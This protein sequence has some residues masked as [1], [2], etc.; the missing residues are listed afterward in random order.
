VKLVRT[1]LVASLA[2]AG[3][4]KSDT[5][6]SQPAPAAPAAAAKDPATAKKLIAGGAV[7][8][9]VR[10]PEEFGDGHVASATNI[11]VQEL[12]TRIAE[13]DKLVGA[14][15]AKPVVVYC[16]AGKRA[17]RAKAQLEAAG[18]THVVNGGGYDD[19]R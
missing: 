5:P 10:T 7:V 4:S 12:A 19:L 6:N 2:L 3:C 13:V 15:K 14:D 9:D 11:P 8:V 17:A 16:S 18:Y 1:L